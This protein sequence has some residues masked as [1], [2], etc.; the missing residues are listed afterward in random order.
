[1]T[2]L[3]VLL[4]GVIIGLS[5][6]AP[7][8]PIGILCIRRTLAKG[9]GAGLA[10]GLGAATAEAFYGCV[11]GLGLTIISGTLIR[12]QAWLRL[13]GGLFL[14][15]LGIKTFLAEPAEEAASTA[16]KGLAGAYASAFTLALANPM[17]ILSF[18]GIFAGL[19]LAR[20]GKDY[21]AAG[22]MVAGVF[23]GSA[24]WRLLLSGAVSLILGK[25]AVRK[26][27]WINRASGVVIT[28]FGLLALLS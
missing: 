3:E 20:D 12:Q 19:G 21:V 15:Y 26:L 7:V 5:V 9:R 27:R 17:T 22:L 13:I 14:C 28:G 25:V 23:A 6:A 2:K 16:G 4:R 8:G 24:L 1:M 18:A 11:A 10:S